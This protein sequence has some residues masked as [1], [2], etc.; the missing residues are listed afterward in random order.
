MHDLYTAKLCARP[1][2]EEKGISAYL[3]VNCFLPIFASDTYIGITQVMEEDFQFIGSPE[4]DPKA[5]E[6]I[7]LQSEIRYLE[8]MISVPQSVRGALVLGSIAYMLTKSQGKNMSLGAAA[9]GAFAG[10]KIGAKK[11][12]S[13]EVIEN[14]KALLEAKKQE[15]YKLV[16]DTKH[17][18][19]T[20]L[21]GTEVINH[22]YK[23]IDFEGKWQEFIGLPSHNFHAMIFGIPKS[24]KSILSVQFADYLSEFGKVCYIA[25]EEG[26]SSTLKQKISD[27]MHNSEKVNFANYRGYNDIKQGIKGYN[28]VFIDSI[29]YAKITVD[30]VEQL[31]DDYPDTAF[32]TIMQATK[33]GN[34][35]GSQEY[36]HNADIIIE[37]ASGVATQR[38][39]FQEE[40]QLSVF[41]GN[42]IEEKP[43]RKYEKTGKY[44]SEGSKIGRP[45]L[46]QEEINRRNANKRPVG[47]PRKYPI[48]QDKEY[49]EVEQDHDL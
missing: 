25:S 5:D 17:D 27:W 26:F 9:L 23:S 39:R 18:S 6:I 24:G 22:E 16:N 4:P 35:R 48:E 1:N 33:G 34:F 42:I 2:R 28:F 15:L 11:E 38:G 10:L 45:K 14:Y 13:P 8:K 3:A 19:S 12:H 20:V 43:K 46:S 32:I 7:E 29:N 40:S 36:A 31:K 30:E 47:R 44:A 49:N 21:S 41:E 37:V